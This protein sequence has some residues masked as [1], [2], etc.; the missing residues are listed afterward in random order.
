MNRTMSRKGR[1]FLACLTISQVALPSFS[2]AGAKTVPDLPQTVTILGETLTLKNTKPGSG[3]DVLGEYIPAGQTFD[4]WTSMFAVRIFHG[5]LTPDQAAQAKRSEIAARRAGGDVMANGVVL[6]K[7][8]TRVVDFLMSQGHV[9]E[10]NIIKYSQYIDGRLA[11]YQL[12]HRF[13][14]STGSEDDHDAFVAFMGE[15]KTKRDSRTVEV[16]RISQD[17]L[18]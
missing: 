9:V 11:G 6:A 3:E 17:L 8:D 14:R 7:G 16:D 12:A 2:Q 13:Y 15:V 10:H 4:N 1:V 18:K 5:R